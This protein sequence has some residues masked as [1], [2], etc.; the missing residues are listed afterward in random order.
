MVALQ[1]HLSVFDHACVDQPPAAG[2]A[3]TAIRHVAILIVVAEDL[4]T[5]GPVWMR[6]VAYGTSGGESHPLSAWSSTHGIVA[7]SK[8]LERYG[9]ARS[10]HML[11]CS[12]SIFRRLLPDVVPLSSRKCCLLPLM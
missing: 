1:S 12:A 4:M 6:F 10:A 5:H 11:R 3:W 7:S 8:F 2:I 9:C